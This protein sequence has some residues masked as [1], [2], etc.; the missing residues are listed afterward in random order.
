MAGP[1]RARYPLSVHLTEE[2]WS[3]L[4][5]LQ[6]ALTKQRG[7]PVSR[8]ETIRWMIEFCPVEPSAT[9]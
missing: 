6:S 8:S 3:K 1:A 9:I 4:E 5:K 2:E 7:T